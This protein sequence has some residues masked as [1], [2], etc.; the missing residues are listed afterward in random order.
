MSEPGKKVKGFSSSNV[1]YLLSLCGLWFYALEGCSFEIQ[2]NF[3]VYGRI[4]RHKKPDHNLIPFEV[5]FLAKR[6]LTQCLKHK[7]REP[8]HFVLI[9]ARKLRH[10]LII[11][12]HCVLLK[13]DSCISI[14]DLSSRNQSGG[15]CPSF[16]LIRVASHRSSKVVIKLVHDLSCPS[17]ILIVIKVD[18]AWACL[19]TSADCSLVSP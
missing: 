4:N 17:A 13:N 5:F 7:K 16:R 10:F 12:K 15:R 6:G 1:T 8:L 19:S 18:L 14:V 2:A 11:F 3:T 9:L